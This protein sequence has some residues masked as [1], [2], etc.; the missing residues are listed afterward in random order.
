MVSAIVLAKVRREVRNIMIG[1]MTRLKVR[2]F[3]SIDRIITTVVIP[4]M[5][6]ELFIT[7]LRQV[8]KLQAS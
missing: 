8:G 6:R 4:H 5:V 7:H 2:P 3:P 1:I